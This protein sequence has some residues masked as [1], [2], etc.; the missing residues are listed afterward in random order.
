LWFNETV[1]DE[2]G[3]QE[4]IFFINAED[5]EE[6]TPKLF[7][8]FFDQAEN[9]PKAPI[10]SQKIEFQARYIAMSATALLATIYAIRNF[11]TNYLVK[12]KTVIENNIN[13]KKEVVENQ[14]K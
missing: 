1:A 9:I 7:K 12:P 4:H 14:Q 6:K 5:L 8:M 2:R 3:T 11:T 10:E 13:K